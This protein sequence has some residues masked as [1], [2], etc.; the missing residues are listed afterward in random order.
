MVK[1]EKI[2]KIDFLCKNKKSRH[3]L[4]KDTT[5][6]TNIQTFKQTFKLTN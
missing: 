2:K 1:I 6:Q 4:T 3:E 5:I